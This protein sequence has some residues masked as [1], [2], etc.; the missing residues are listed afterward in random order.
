MMSPNRDP[1]FA[2]LLKVRSAHET[3]PVRALP[4]S[5]GSPIAYAPHC[6]RQGV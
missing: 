2:S 1:A 6:T 4:P 5:A 3:G